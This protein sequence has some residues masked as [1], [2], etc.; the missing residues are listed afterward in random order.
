MLYHF[1]VPLAK[2][3]IVFNVFRYLTFRS[4][5]ALISALVIS[6][7]VG[8]WLI[9]RLRVMQHG[10]ETIREDT[11]ERHRDKKGTPTMG[12]VVILTAH[13]RLDAAVGESAEPLRVGRDAGDGRLRADRHLGRLDQ[14]AQAR[15]GLSAR[16]KFAAAGSCWRCALLQIV[17]W[18]PPSDWLPV[19]AIP[20]FKGWLV[21]LGWLV[22]PVRDARRR[23]R[24]ERGE[25]DR[26]A[27]RP[28]DRP[29]RHGRRRLRRPRVPD[30]QL[31]GRRLSE[32]PERPR[33]RAS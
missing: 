12:G 20:F 9:R 21:N 1:L 33:G 29:D 8:P 24:L 7:V 14:A 5:M 28:G 4:F 31:P 26:R 23:R 3:H 22:D 13:P 19:L 27:R 32:D 16:V 18:Q 15:K 17:F 10:A 2:D 6:L 11:P 30:R 25:P